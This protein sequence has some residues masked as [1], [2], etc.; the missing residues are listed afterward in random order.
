MTSIDWSVLTA[1]LAG[2]LGLG[3]IAMTALRRRGMRRRAEYAEIGPRG[4]RR[5]IDVVAIDEAAG[6][7]LEQE[8]DE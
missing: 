5:R 3:L 1:G 2:G 6:L 7:S 4:R 8:E